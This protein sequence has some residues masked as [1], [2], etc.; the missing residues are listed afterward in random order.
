MMGQMMY[1]DTF[2]GKKA[3]ITGG[4]GFIGSS[5]AEQLVTLGVQV[6][7]VDA[8]LPL[9]G[10]NLF[11]LE[12]IKD[13]VTFIQGDIRDREL[14]F[15]LVKDQDYI[16]DLAAQVSYLDS[17]DIPFVDL[18]I[19]CRGHLNVLEAVRQVSPQARVLFAS[20]R[21]VYGKILTVPVTED[22]PT[23][24]LS[25]YGIHKL[26]AEKYYR[27]YHDTFGLDTISVR[28]PNPYGP[29]QQ[30]KHNKYSIVGWFLR[31]ALED[32]TI[33]IFGDGEQERDYLYIDDIV[34]AFLALAAKGQAGEAYNL[35]TRERVTFV[36]MVDEILTVAGT[37]R[38]NHIPWP[39]NYE[40][41]ETGNY[42]ADTGKIEAATGWEAKV[43]LREGIRKM[44]DY[45]RR[46]QGHYW[47]QTGD[48][49]L[50][51]I[52]REYIKQRFPRASQAER[53]KYVKDWVNKVGKSN[54]V[55][56]DF[57]KRT[58]TDLADQKILEAGCGNGGMA[59]AFAQAGAKMVGV[60]IEPELVEIARAQA[61]AYNLEAKFEYYDGEH[62]PFDDGSFD[63]ALSVSV[64]EHVTDP[65][66]YL[67]ELLRVV[68]SDGYLYLAFP[69]RLWPRETHTRLWFVSWLPLGL[70]D[71]V[72]R[73]F[74]RNPL[75]DNNLHFY[76]LWSLKRMLKQTKIADCHWEIVAEEG[77][78]RNP[79]KNLVKK[80][81]GWL[82]LSYKTFLPHVSV[83]LK[84]M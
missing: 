31:Q 14:M 78:S 1:R 8:L 84:K 80:I 65:V 40:K 32:K 9:Y 33:T 56:D 34:D 42:V 49:S 39:T 68:K 23:N 26:T 3:L 58:G 50:P 71:P 24:P 72:V 73:W 28:I 10:G 18:D 69:N 66:N 48:F 51:H 67:T 35:G 75:A 52:A 4:A 77:S 17:K 20:S 15:K 70:I 45:Y 55:A 76:T 19:N 81:L 16:F 44:V 82:G 60:E 22:H 59:I 7:V 46:H 54:G 2:Q 38:K 5:L 21:L 37:G 57:A 13:K 83:I 27:Y 11:N 12:P 47:F 61:A 25:I 53:D 62:L 29:R 43:G 6:T 74:G 64:L 41:N 79:L 36:R 63:A 30:M